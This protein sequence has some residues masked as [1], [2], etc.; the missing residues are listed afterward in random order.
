ISGSQVGLVAVLL[1]WPLSRFFARLLRLTSFGRVTLA[2]ELF[3]VVL[4]LVFVPI[5]GAGAPVLRSALSYALGACAPR[6][7][8]Q[9]AFARVRGK[10]V[11]LGRK[12]DPISLWALALTFECLLHSDAP[13]SLSVQLSYGATLGLMLGTGPI[14]AWLRALLG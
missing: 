2:P 11:R 14:L 13:R 7:P 10:D 9:R 1:L 6:A 4:L 8:M 5:A 3:H 12:A